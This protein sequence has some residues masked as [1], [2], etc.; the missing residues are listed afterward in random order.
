MSVKDCAATL[1]TSPDKIKQAYESGKL[2]V[3]LVKK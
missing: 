2:I 1:A 3:E